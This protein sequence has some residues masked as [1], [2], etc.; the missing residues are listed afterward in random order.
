MSYKLNTVVDFMD[1]NGMIIT[2]E[3]LMIKQLNSR[4]GLN[5]HHDIVITSH[6]VQALKNALVA[7]QILALSNSDE[8]LE[9]LADKALAILEEE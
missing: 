7:L 1:E 2:D 3:D 5:F 8:F 6:E 9:K 4:L